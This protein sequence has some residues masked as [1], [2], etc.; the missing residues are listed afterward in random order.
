MGIETPRVGLLNVGMEKAKGDELA[1][2]AFELL[3]SDEALNFVGNIE[4]HQIIDGACDVLVCGGF[5]GNVLLKFY[6][7]IAG[8]VVK[9]LHGDARTGQNATD[10]ERVFRVLDYAEYGGAP[11]LGV[12]GVSIVCHGGS[13]PRAIKN[14]IGVAVRSLESGLIGDMA[15]DLAGLRDAGVES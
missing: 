2:A 15:R 6:E 3:K 1:V 14:A 10:L 7:S 4:G 5:V 12:N 11:L 9:L 8:F 13:S